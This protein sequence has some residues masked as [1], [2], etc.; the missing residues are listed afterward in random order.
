MDTYLEQV[1][2][3][4]ISLT[5]HEQSQQTHFLRSQ[6]LIELFGRSSLLKQSD[7]LS[8]HLRRHWGTS[9][10]GL[11]DCFEQSCRRGVLQ[12]IPA[13]SS[14]DGCEYAVFIGIYR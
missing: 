13:G 12:Q 5:F 7:H 10:V 2:R 14:T 3:S 4:L 9:V 6:A 1:G 8:G 11:R